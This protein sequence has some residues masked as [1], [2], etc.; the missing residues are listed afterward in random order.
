[1]LLVLATALAFAVALYVTPG[2][3]LYREYFSTDW[4]HFTHWLHG[5][6]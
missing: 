5:L 2:G 3:A 4:D 1:V 6:F